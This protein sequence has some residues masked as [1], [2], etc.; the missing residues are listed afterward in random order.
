MRNRNR[1]IR[2]SK[3]LCGIFLLIG[4]APATLIQQSSAATSTALSVPQMRETL[5]WSDEFNGHG[6]RSAPDAAKWTYD[7]GHGKWGNGE[8][9]TY[10]AHGSNAF[11][12][13]LDK[14]NVYVG[15]DGYLHILARKSGNIYTS[16]RIKTE[17]L[18]SFQYGRIEARIRIPAGQG[19]WPAFWML[20]DSIEK[21]GWPKCGEFDVMEN[22][23]KES[24]TVHG[25]IHGQGFVGTLI[26]LPYVNQGHVPFSAGFHTFGLI[27][28]PGKVE[29]YVDDPTN[30]YARFTPANLPA[31]VIWPFDRG[32]FFL[33]LNVAVGG[34]WG[35]SPDQTTHFPAEMLVDYVRVWQKSASGESIEK[36]A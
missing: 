1:A 17:G 25:S 24:A 5:V 36:T 13:R 11:P 32:K 9:E 19:I 3:G 16:A 14:P 7:V 31:G 12:C 15:G 26:G 23:G 18:A 34:D 28:S 29:Y 33:I 10:C 20:G 22:I 4:F 8:L 30:V 6:A 21:V 35:G 2:T 27:W